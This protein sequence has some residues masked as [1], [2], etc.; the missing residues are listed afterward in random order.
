ML[1]A[2]SLTADVGADTD[3]VNVSNRNEISNLNAALLLLLLLQANTDAV[4][5]FLA[6]GRI[7]IMILLNGVLISWVMI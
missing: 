2:P 5:L 1:L 6:V 7:R 4:S 3:V